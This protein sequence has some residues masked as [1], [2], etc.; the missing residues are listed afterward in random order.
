MGFLSSSKLRQPFRY[1]EQGMSF[2]LRKEKKSS[3]KPEMATIK[4]LVKTQ[5]WLLAP[6]TM[7]QLNPKKLSWVAYTFQGEEG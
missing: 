5:E 6:R 3:P 7:G 1:V 4:D 2:R